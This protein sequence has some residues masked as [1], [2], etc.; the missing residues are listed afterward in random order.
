MLEKLVRGAGFEPAMGLRPPD[1]ESLITLRGRQRKPSQ[2][3]QLTTEH[4]ITVDNRLIPEFRSWL[5][6]KRKIKESTARDYI[7]ALRKLEGKVITP[8]SLIKLYGKSKYYVLA[9]RLYVQFLE[10][11]GYISEE[12][13][14]FWLKRLKVRRRSKVDVREV[15]EEEV[16]RA[17][18]T[19]RGAERHDIELAYLIMLFS[20]CRLSEAIE[21]INSFDSSRLHKV[22]NDYSRYGLMK[23]DKSKRALWLYLPNSLIDLLKERK[24]KISRRAV[25][26][27]A[28]RN[29]ILAPKYIRKFFYQKAYEVLHDRE[30]VDFYQGRVSRLSIGSRHYDSLLSRADKEYA[31]IMNYLRGIIHEG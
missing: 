31:K 20:G 15:K 27:F 7:N 23:T 2:Y 6:L 9:L 30:L 26:E 13:S 21:L 22:N 17:V 28:R 25:T 29:K 16:R 11:L 18:K 3:H 19:I 10:D 24:Y 1:L 14:S 5:I 12:E 8:R 4:E